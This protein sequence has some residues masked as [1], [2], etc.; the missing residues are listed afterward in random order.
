MK[1][2]KRGDIIYVDLGQ[3][4]KSSVQSGVRPCIVVSNNKNNWFANVL[5]VLPFS[6]QLKDNPVHVRIRP[7]D[8]NGYCEKESDCLTEQIVT[9]DKSKVIIKAG[10]IPKDTEVMKSI[11]KAIC[12]QLDLR[13]KDI[14]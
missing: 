5:N 2:I 8:V 4:P 3:H 10:H 7:N 6:A 11:N 1:N 13:V 9:I 12:V 14:E